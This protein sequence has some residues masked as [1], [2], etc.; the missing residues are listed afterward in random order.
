MAFNYE[1][2][3]KYKSESFVDGTIT[4]TQIESL[5]VTSDKINTDAVTSDKLGTGSVDLGSDKVS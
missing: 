2:L 1:T 4:G 5:G 3:K